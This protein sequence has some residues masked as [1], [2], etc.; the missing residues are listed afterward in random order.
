MKDGYPGYRDHARLCTRL[1]IATTYSTSNSDDDQRTQVFVKDKYLPHLD[2]LRALAFLIVTLF[3][4]R[5]PGTS[6]GYLGVDIFLVLSG[7]LMT[8][9]IVRDVVAGTFRVR[10]FM[11]RRFWRLYPTL[12]VTTAVTL[13]ASLAFFSTKLQRRVAESTIAALLFVSNHYFNATTNYFDVSSD[14]KPLLH[15]WSL[16]LEE[17][18]YV[19]WPALII[20]VYHNTRES[21]VALALA[22]CVTITMS[23]AFALTTRSLSVVFFLLPARVFEFAVGG[24]LA[25]C[26]VRLALAIET[27]RLHDAC[28]ALGAM[29]VTYPVF[30]APNTS[31]PGESSAIT[32]IGTVLLMVSPRS[33]VAR[34]VLSMRSLRQIGKLSYAGYLAHWPV[35]VYTTFVLE[36]GFEA[37]VNKGALFASTLVAAYVLHHGVENKLRHT[38]SRSALCATFVLLACTLLLAA[39]SVYTRGFPS[40]TN[41]NETFNMLRNAHRYNKQL[42]RNIPSNHT[43]FTNLAPSQIPRACYIGA[44]PAISP[45]LPVSAVIVGSSFAFQLI[46]GFRLLSLQRNEG[47]LFLH[48]ES[49]AL[50]ASQHRWPW[51]TEKC[52]RENVRRLALLRILA[53]SRI[54]LADYWDERFS[55]G[56]Y[57]EHA[58]LY[59]STGALP[60]FRGNCASLSQMGHSVAVAGDTPVMGE[61]H[62]EATRSCNLLRNMRIRRWAS[63]LWGGAVRR[64]RVRYQPGAAQVRLNEE[65]KKFFDKEP[66]GCIFHDQFKS[67]CDSRDLSCMIELQ[68]VS[69]AVTPKGATISTHKF[70]PLYWEGVHINDIGS[71]HTST[72]FAQLLDKMPCPSNVSNRTQLPVVSVANI[73]QSNSKTRS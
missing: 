7:F 39:L 45:R 72:R 15:T 53:P 61:C 8:R 22:F 17:Q 10:D 73:R 3:H 2:G 24:L 31:R 46:H 54:I 44:N 14:L 13:L 4:F 27:V 38:R 36:S 21:K 37:N 64:C 19:I 65:L 43:L 40:R 1:E 30:H 69:H 71:W 57:N 50:R 33:L 59:G 67:F 20:L 35:W 62:F 29:L 49:C 32:L 47:Y 9:I 56:N 26:Y 23:L 25:L 51:L 55:Q 70:N 34:K 6:G 18:F 48:H 41:N 66:S 52:K 12:L 58:K 16:S 11:I 28:G 68:N 63:S 5:V 60:Y 42:C